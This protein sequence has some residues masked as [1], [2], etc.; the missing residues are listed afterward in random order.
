MHMLVI[1]I[2]NAVDQIKVLDRWQLYG[3]YCLLLL[4]LP[5]CDCICATGCCVFSTCNFGLQ[6]NQ[7]L[8]SNYGRLWEL[9][10]T[11]E[12]FHSCSSTY[13]TGQ[14]LTACLQHFMPL[15]L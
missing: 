10:Q 1:Q 8:P 3:L 2:A 15:M 11:P 4:L 14:D 12:L 5:F 13:F 6:C 7:E 9:T